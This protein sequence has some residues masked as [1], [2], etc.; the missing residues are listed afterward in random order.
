MVSAHPPQV[1]LE[2]GSGFGF[3]PAYKQCA[4][5]LTRESQFSAP[6]LQLFH[7]ANGGKLHLVV[8]SARGSEGGICKRKNLQDN[9]IS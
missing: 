8:H 3:R 4:P 1:I 9:G 6:E 7:L 2:T 5:A